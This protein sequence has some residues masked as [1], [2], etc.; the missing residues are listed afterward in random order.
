M[1]DDL[2]GDVS[3]WHNERHKAKDARITAQEAEIR[4]LRAEL[5]KNYPQI[6]F[7]NARAMIK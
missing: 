6:I 1:T 7:V 3:R 2:I 4:R 5:K